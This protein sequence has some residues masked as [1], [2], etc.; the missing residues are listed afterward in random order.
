MDYNTFHNQIYV[1]GWSQDCSLVG[2]I[3]TPNGHL[4]L[5]FNRHPCHQL[6]CDSVWG[7]FPHL[8]DCRT[9]FVALA[10]LW[11]F[12]ARVA[13]VHHSR[14][15]GKE[16]SKTELSAKQQKAYPNASQ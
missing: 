16:E 11:N 15:L 4:A 3:Q 12:S 8:V 14:E 13:S 7:R 6:G 1:Q 2:L 5:V 10:I 9:P